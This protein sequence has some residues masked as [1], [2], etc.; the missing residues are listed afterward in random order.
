MKHVDHVEFAPE[1]A[2][3]G[4]VV[5]D[6]RAGLDL[7]IDAYR[8]QLHAGIDIDGVEFGIGRVAQ[9]AAVGTDVD[10]AIGDGGRA[11]DVLVHVNRPAHLTRDHVQRVQISVDRADT[12][13]AAIGYNRAIQL[14]HICKLGQFFA[15]GG[16]QGVTIAQLRRDIDHVIGDSRAREDRRLQGHAPIFLTRGGIQGVDSVVR[17]RVDH[18]SGNHGHGLQ[19]FIGHER[20]SLLTRGGVQRVDT[21]MHIDLARAD[22]DQAF[23]HR[24]HI[25]DAVRDIRG[26]QQTTGGHIQRVH[27][28]TIVRDA[29]RRGIGARV[30]GA[31]RGG[32][33][34]IVGMIHARRHVPYWD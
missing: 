4:L 22:I 26:P 2:D 14:A 17:V 15:R 23:D 12:D 10:N 33:L 29:L 20:P 18:S 32:W 25:K 34:R 19:V 21:A 6:D 7:V 8:P 31:V 5:N 16:I 1:G 9:E 30:D 11:R 13:D 3:V 24:G 27:L 28:R